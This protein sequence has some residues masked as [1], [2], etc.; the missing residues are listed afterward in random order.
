[1]NSACLLSSVLSAWSDLPMFT[2]LQLARSALRPS[3][4]QG[5]RNGLPLCTG[6]FDD[7]VAQFTAC[8]DAMSTHL[9]STMMG[10][11]KT[12]ASKHYVAAILDMAKR[13]YDV[14]GRMQREDIDSSICT[15]S[16]VFHIALMTLGHQ[17]TFVGLFITTDR[18]GMIWRGLAAQLDLWVLKH[19][20]LH[21]ALQHLSYFQAR[22]L[23]VD[24]EGMALLL[25]SNHTPDPLNYVPM[26]REACV[27]L[28]LEQ[29]KIEELRTAMD[30]EEDVERCRQIL[31]TLKITRLD[32]D[33]ILQLLDAVHPAHS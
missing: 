26:C 18:F 22:Q 1:M 30:A 28:R 12:Y 19:I 11:F 9:I 6:Y 20:L 8:T 14:D 24:V 13:T 5:E 21:S 31:R 4:T 29:A 23:Q 17:V 3:P 27:L 10:P 33:H 7:L 32:R 25:F 2:E 15:I 16:P